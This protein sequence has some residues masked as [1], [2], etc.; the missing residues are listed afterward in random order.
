VEWP[1]RTICGRLPYVRVG[2]NFSRR[3]WRRDQG[4]RSTLVSTRPT[5]TPNNTEP[6]TA[7]GHVPSCRRRVSPHATR[8]RRWRWEQM[9]CISGPLKEG[10][11]LRE[12]QRG[13]GFRRQHRF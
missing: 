5:P 8:E 7:L 4:D 12:D 3:T 10:S 2:N 1:M 11:V 9:S 6:E 13:R